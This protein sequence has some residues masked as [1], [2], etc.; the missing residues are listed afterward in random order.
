MHGSS[1]VGLTARHLLDVM[2]YPQQGTYS[3]CSSKGECGF[4][5]KCKKR[6]KEAKMEGREGVRKEGREKTFKLLEKV[7][8]RNKIEHHGALGRGEHMQ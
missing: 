8:Q 3:F 5:K 2:I 1:K 7:R 4:L 6:K